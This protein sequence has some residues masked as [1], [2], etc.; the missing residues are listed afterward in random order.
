M[1]LT[2]LTRNPTIRQRIIN[3]CALSVLKPNN[4]I[5]TVLSNKPLITTINLTMSTSSKYNFDFSST[6]GRP[7]TCKAAIAWEANKPLSVEDVI[8][9]TPKAGMAMI[10]YCNI[11]QYIIILIFCG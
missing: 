6:Q 1:L 11:Q 5:N 2:H 9:E 8:V 4:T 7:I 3:S 10:S